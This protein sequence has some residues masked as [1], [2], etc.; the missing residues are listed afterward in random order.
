[1]K[2]Y[3]PALIIVCVMQVF[4]N[5]SL[6]LS[7]RHDHSGAFR[8]FAADTSLHH[9]EYVFPDGWIYVYDIDNGFLPVKSIPIPTS[10]GTR[11]VA[12]SPGDR[13]LYI[14]YG[15]DGGT[16]GNGSLLQYD[17]IGDSVRWTKSYAHGVDS[18]AITPDGKT[19]FMPSGELSPNGNW[20]VLNAADGSE[21]GVITTNG[22]GPHNTAVSLDGANVYMGCR[23]TSGI[24]NDSFYVASAA[25]YQVTKSIGRTLNGVRPLTVNGMQTFAFIN[26]TGL[27]GFQVC[28]L[29]ANTIA[30]TIDLTTL[31]FSDTTCGH[32]C[33]SAPSHGI[34]LSPDE[35]RVFVVDSPNSYVHVFDVS[36]L[37]YGTPPVKIADI[38]LKHPLGTYKKGCAYDCQRT[39]WLQHSL[40]GRFVFV[41]DA[42]DVIETATDSIVAFLPA[43]NDSRVM[44]E[45]DWQKGGPF[46]SSSRN[47]LGYVTNNSCPLAPILFSPDSAAVIQLLAVS[48]HWKSTLNANKYHVQAALDSNFA[49]IVFDDSTVTDTSRQLTGLSDSTKYFWRV[50]AKNN[51]G[52]S[53]TSATWSFTTNAGGAL[54]IQMSSFTGT[55]DSSN[56]IIL[57]WTTVSEV[58][59]YGFEVQRSA[60]GKQF[61]TLPNSFISGHGT[62][63]E[64]NLYSFT[65]QT[66][67]SGKWYY[68]LKQINLDGTFGY[69]SVI[70]VILGTL[71]VKEITAPHEFMLH[72]NYPNPFNPSTE[73][74]FEIPARSVVR[75]II[76]N[77]I[78]QVVAT[79]VDGIEDAGYRISRWNTGTMPSGIY[80][81][82]LEAVI[83]SAPEKSFV[84]VRKMI[85]I[86]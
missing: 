12:V 24:G 46:A 27:L 11:G 47:G 30:Y 36:G 63:L 2:Y 76:Y 17:L 72:Q 29:A 31:G 53:P 73:I 34:S 1:M 58:N 32:H 19:L 4:A 6:R 18:H 8:S 55:V 60:G 77:V 38:K 39:G 48:L 81:Y 3:L 78:G 23:D 68:R 79:L 33:A 86:K 43:M 13:M 52:T 20:Y 16:Y 37:S 83:T 9:Y 41:G 26:V 84:Q 42:G 85:L 59:S 66:A 45:I 21:K 7:Q 54:P 10:Q 57:N 82:K 44:L 22:I 80:F 15:G 69:G 28:D 65:D 14:S 56:H 50:E 51:Y 62:S 49:S 5:H 25:T 61:Q 64:S 71:G 70:Q 40:D 74:Q 67:G 35:T 75:L